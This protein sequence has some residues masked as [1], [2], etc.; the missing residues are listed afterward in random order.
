M[1]SKSWTRSEVRRAQYHTALNLPVVSP[2]SRC[3]RRPAPTLG[4]A[5]P[6]LVLNWCTSFAL[7]RSWLS[8]S[9]PFEAPMT[10]APYSV[11]LFLKF[12]MTLR[13]QRPQSHDTRKSR[14]PLTLGLSILPSS[15]PAQAIH[16][17]SSQL[18]QF[19]H[20]LAHVKAAKRALS[21]VEA[22]RSL[23]SQKPTHHSLP[24][25]DNF[26]VLVLAGDQRQPSNRP[27]RI[28]GVLVGRPSQ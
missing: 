24:R 2:G 17:R 1:V 26:V 18:P 28:R 8:A 10:L 14:G 25:R 6:S 16:S 21:L 5:V 12:C 3:A 4:E 23:F 7:Q 22:C 15:L 11:L 19:H 13:S 20:P 9:I 27:Q